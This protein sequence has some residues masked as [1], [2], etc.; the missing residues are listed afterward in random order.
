MTW[1]RRGLLTSPLW[2]PS[3]PVCPPLEVVSSAVGAACPRGEWACERRSH[4][5]AG[6]GEDVCREISIS[7]RVPSQ[8][9]LWLRPPLWYLRPKSRHN[10]YEKT[11][12]T[13]LPPLC[14][15]PRSLLPDWTCFA[16]S[17]PPANSTHPES[18]SELQLGHHPQASLVSNASAPASSRAEH[19]PG[20][21]SPSQSQRSWPR[22]SPP[23]SSRAS[24]R[25]LRAQ[26]AATSQRQPPEG[27]K[28]AQPVL[29]GARISSEMRKEPCPAM[30]GWT[31]ISSPGP[32][33][34]R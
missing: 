33:Q 25:R 26:K 11:P 5:S 6:S 16:S 31:T 23:A 30:G 1:C 17:P 4:S 18:I 3:P 8:S 27:G 20:A 32:C 22:P 10:F 13:G 9:R 21:R 19:G 28:K 12:F 29:F 7:A 14:H 2:S 24:R 34:P 15:R